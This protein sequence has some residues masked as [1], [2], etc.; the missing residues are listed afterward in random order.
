MI[1][2]VR[3][4]GTEVMALDLTTHQDDSAAREHAEFGFS[5]GSGG[6]YDIDYRDTSEDVHA[7]GRTQ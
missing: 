7:R 1:I 3:I 5:G 6:Q 2:T 4:L